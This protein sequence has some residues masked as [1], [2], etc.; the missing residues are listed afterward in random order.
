M[1]ILTF[2]KMTSLCQIRA[3][4]QGGVWLVCFHLCFFVPQCSWS[5]W[6]AS[7]RKQT[8]CWENSNTSKSTWKRLWR[9]V[10]TTKHLNTC[11]Y[12]FGGNVLWT[13]KYISYCISIVIAVSTAPCSSRSSYH[14]GIKNNIYAH[15]EN[16][17]G[18]T[19]RS[20]TFNP[21]VFL[22][23]ITVWSI[24]KCWV[25]FHK[26]ISSPELTQLLICW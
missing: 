3:E 15:G 18:W 24:N 4:R 10:S 23:Y 14:S 9:S 16:S 17:H 1:K 2:N 26:W 25:M 11:Q 22:L 13:Y 19:S 6:R 7:R 21:L 8:S 12:D 20:S 5:T